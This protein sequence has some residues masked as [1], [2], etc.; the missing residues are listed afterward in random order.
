MLS[1]IAMLPP[2]QHKRSLCVLRAR[3][4]AC[5]RGR[6]GVM[7]V[8]ERCERTL[9]DKIAYEAVHPGTRSAAESSEHFTAKQQIATILRDAGVDVFIEYRIRTD[10]GHRRID[11]AIPSARIA[12]EI[13]RTWRARNRWWE[14]QRTAELNDAGWEVLNY[15]PDHVYR[16]GL[17]SRVR[18]TFAYQQQA[19]SPMQMAMAGLQVSKWRNPIPHKAWKRMTPYERSKT[20]VRLYN[21]VRQ[22]LI[23]EAAH[24]G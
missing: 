18:D 11:V 17:L 9:R 22:Q 8:L 21:E 7:S 14:R 23:I 20:L 10:T 12:I 5:T 6:G 19:D 24:R 15:R 16:L 1:P 4:S 3:C 2:P 13:R